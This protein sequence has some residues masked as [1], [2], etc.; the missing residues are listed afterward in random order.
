MSNTQETKKEGLRNEQPELESSENIS[1]IK[2]FDDMGLKEDLL[3][4]I[5]AYGWEKPS[6]I[7][8]KAIIPITSKP[9]R[10]IIAQAQSGTGKTGTFSIGLLQ[11]LDFTKNEVQG[12]VLANTR[13]LAQQIHKVLLALGERMGVKIHA[14]VGGTRVTD[15][16]QMLKEG[17]HVVV[18][19]P[20]RVN[21]MLEEGFLK[22]DHIQMLV[23][24]EADEMLSPGFKDQIYD[25]FKH[26]PEDVQVLLF[27]AT[28]APDVLE[29]TEKFMRNPVRLLVKKEQLTLEGLKQFYIAVEREEN[30][31]PT[32]CD[33]YK[34]LTI[35]QCVIFCNS[36]KRVEHLA[37]AMNR[38]DFTV[39]FIHG[40]MEQKERELV[41]KE[42]RSGASRV[43]ITTDLMA[44][45][46]DVHQISLVINYDLPP[47]RQNYIHRIGRSARYGRKG[48]A[49]NFVTDR[50]I[51]DMRELE[52][53]Y[54][55]Q[56]EEMP[57]DISD[58]L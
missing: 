35:T 46:I 8:Q 42:F 58:L 18:G 25:I 33:L 6:Q 28:L 19:T 32:L 54:N 56:I 39:S 12:L 53:Y 52:R 31:F 22:P 20:G 50:D 13:E 9:Q 15:D 30:K 2:E 38:K 27:S 48:V 47:L 40:G 51:R 17:V 41:L 49:I 14:C 43:L 45:G 37:E 24:D 29:I 5:F 23:I 3:R 16:I 7:Q 10:D 57:E 21:H 26:L 44:R 4:G 11:N 36:K 55:T 34:T 1:I